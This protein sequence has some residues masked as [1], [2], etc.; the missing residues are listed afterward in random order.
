MTP[1][2]VPRLLLDEEVGEIDPEKTFEFCSS[3]KCSE[4]LRKH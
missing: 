3:L 4:P 2:T 1:L